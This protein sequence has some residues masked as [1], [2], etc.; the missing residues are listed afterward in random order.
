MMARLRG[1]W[2]GTLY[3]RQFE[4]VTRAGYPLFQPV[5]E[6]TAFGGKAGVMRQI[7]PL[8]RILVQVEHQPG[9]PLEHHVLPPVA[10]HYPAPWTVDAVEVS[11]RYHDLEKCGV[12]LV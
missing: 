6:A 5:L 9:L 2:D 11:R 7:D 3:R 10:G 12:R 4:A 1:R 8:V